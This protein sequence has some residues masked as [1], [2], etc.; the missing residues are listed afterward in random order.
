MEQVVTVFG[1]GVMGPT[2][3]LVFRKKKNGGDSDKN[4]TNLIKDRKTCLI[5]RDSRAQF[6]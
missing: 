1:N 6:V 4:H 3:V 2:V 5:L